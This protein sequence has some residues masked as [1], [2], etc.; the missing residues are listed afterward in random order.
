M[1]RGKRRKA[2]VSLELG[3]AFVL[4][5]LLL[6]ASFNLARW[7]VGRLVLRQETYEASRQGASDPFQHL[8]AEDD[9]STAPPL[10]FFGQ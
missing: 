1:L 3:T 10:R 9:E 5:F 6:F 4:I 2:Q 7:I 8:G